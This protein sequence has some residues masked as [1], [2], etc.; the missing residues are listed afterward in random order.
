MAYCFTVVCLVTWPMNTS[1]AWFMQQKQWGLIKTR[2]PATSLPFKGQVTGQT[3]VKWSNKTPTHTKER[4]TNKQT[5]Q[6]SKNILFPIL[7]Q[8]NTLSLFKNCFPVYAMWQ[9]GGNKDIMLCLNCSVHYC[10]STT[11]SY[12]HLNFNLSCSLG[13]LIKVLP[14]VY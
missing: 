10:L 2:S 8:N 5:L 7:Y 14:E 9:L 12:F 4:Q 1:Q 13:L 3:T 11:K 6:N